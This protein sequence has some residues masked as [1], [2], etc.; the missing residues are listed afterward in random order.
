MLSAYLVQTAEHKPRIGMTKRSEPIYGPAAT[1]KCRK[2]FKVQEIILPDKQKIQ[3]DCTYYLAQPVN[4]GDTLDGR[5]VL[6][7]EP[8]HA[9]NGEV[10]GYKAVV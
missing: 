7:V 2:Q 4:A 1:L 9:L 8:W 6:A 3:S 10:I 5:N